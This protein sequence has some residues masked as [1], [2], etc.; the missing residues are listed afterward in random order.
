MKRF[1]ANEPRRMFWSQDVG[2]HTSCPECK[3][4]L[5]NEQHTYVMATRRQGQLDTFLVGNDGGY[6]CGGCATVVLDNDEFAEAAAVALGRT[7][8][9]EFVILGL[10]DLQAVP[11]E[12]ARAPL[13]A[14]GNPVP[15]VG[16]TN[17]D[18]PGPRLGRGAGKGRKHSRKPHM[19]QRTP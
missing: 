2:G 15:L 5:A 1:P 19:N 10:V 13:G 8:G 9:A 3:T 14:D 11:K 7:R 4:P 16:F 18:A 6:F 17:L 12:K